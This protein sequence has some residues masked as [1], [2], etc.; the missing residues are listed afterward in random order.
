M[1][2]IELYQLET[3]PFC[4]KV[5]SKLD[6][7]DLDYTTVNVTP[8]DRPEVAE[9]TGG[10]TMVPVIKDP[11]TEQFDWMNESGDIVD[12]LEETYGN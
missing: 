9:V 12:Y 8:P 1:E 3:C 4:A 11:N 7:L 5:R 6:E 2:A 10:E